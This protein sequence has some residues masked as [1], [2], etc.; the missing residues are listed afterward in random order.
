MNF[1][2]IFTALLLSISMMAGAQLRT[3]SEA[4]EVRMADVRLPSSETGTISFKKCKECDFVIRRV[5]RNTEY[6]F[7]GEKM[8]LEKFRQAVN[9]VDRSLDIPV[10]VVH[11]LERDEI[12]KLFVVVH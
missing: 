8:S 2:M 11:H 4:Y 12:T 6:E 1:K 5:S 7:N 3:I 10:Q 9:G